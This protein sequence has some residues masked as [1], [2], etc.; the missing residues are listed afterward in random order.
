MELLLTFALWAG[1]AFLM[2]RFGCGAHATGHGAHESGNPAEGRTRGERAPGLAP[3]EK[4]IDPVCGETV[5]T[6]HAKPSV[7]DGRVYYFCSRDCREIFEAAPELYL[8][9]AEPRQC[10]PEH[11][12]A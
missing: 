2:M 9:G 3:P 6:A 12:H 1:L 4:D 11:S 8:A 10:E 7:H 5:R